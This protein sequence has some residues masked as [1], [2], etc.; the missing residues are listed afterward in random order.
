MSHW[1]RLTGYLKFNRYLIK[2]RLM[3]E[4]FII[5][6]DSNIYINTF[7]KRDYLWNLFDLTNLLNGDKLN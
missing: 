1:N 2:E 7:D 5:M 4:N 3:Y 6:D